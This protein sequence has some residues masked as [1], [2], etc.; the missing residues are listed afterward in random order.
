M[1]AD[2]PDRDLITLLNHARERANWQPGKSSWLCR[3]TWGE[4]ID[5]KWH[6]ARA[7][8]TQCHKTSC[9]CECHRPTDADRELWTRIA[10][11][12]DTYL[13]HP[14]ATTAPEGLF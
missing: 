4:W 6:T 13:E 14:T 5:G 8:H 9:G 2:K 3:P 1:S 12:I 11:E 10:D 7:N